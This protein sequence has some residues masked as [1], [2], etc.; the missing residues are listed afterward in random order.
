MFL[1][2]GFF[3]LLSPLDSAV[4]ERLEIKSEN[5]VLIGDMHPSSGKG[6][7][8]DL[9]RYRN[10][11]MYLNGIHSLPEPIPVRIF[12]TTGDKD[13]KEMSG[14]VGIGGVYVSNIEGPIFMLNAKG[15]FRSG[16]HGRKYAM[17]EY[18]HHLVAGYTNNHFPLWYNEGYANYLA[19][20]KLGRQGRVVIGRLEQY[21]AWPLSSEEWM[22]AKKVF[23]AINRYPFV[24]SSRKRNRL[25]SGDMFYAQTW[26]AVHYIQSHPEY[27]KKLEKY[28][29]LLNSERRPD[30][31]FVTAFGHSM[32]DFQLKLKDYFKKNKFKIFA[33]NQEPSITEAR[34]QVRS[35]SRGEFAFHRAEAM[36][37]YRGSA[38]STQEIIDQY[39]V[40]AKSI[41]ETPYILAGLAELATWQDDFDSAKIYIDKALAQAPNDAKVNHMAGMIIVYKLEDQSVVVKRGEILQARRHLKKAMIKNH[42]DI[43]AHFY[44]AKTF[45]LTND[46]PNAQALASAATALEYYRGNRF[47]DSNLMLADVLI[48]GGETEIV[49]PIIEQAI[50]WG[51]DG[52]AVSRAIEL[53]EYLNSK[54]R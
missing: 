39:K 20:F 3:L 54:T 43:S 31:V 38:I 16:R 44:Y 40:A 36:R 5:F 34:L 26:L 48:R 4:A 21:Y 8:I 24:L 23:G 28:I 35:L 27:V 49:R 12:A 14:M 1:I 15:G 37:Y 11:I 10:A 13:L 9:E 25:N 22:P 2:T 6:L 32:E 18:A 42:D 30:D 19:S 41:G 29:N 51:R 53:R 52:A 46:N 45:G 7:L 50:I 47:I 33:I 17:H